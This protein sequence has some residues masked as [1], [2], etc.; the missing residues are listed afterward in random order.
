[1]RTRSLTVLLLVLLFALPAKAQ[2]SF[3]DFV[4]GTQ[5]AA[6]WN[7]IIAEI[8]AVFD[9]ILATLG[10]LEQFE[11]CE[12]LVVPTGLTTD[13]GV[14]FIWGARTATTLDKIRCETDTGTATINLQRDDGASPANIATSNLV[15]DTTGVETTT[16][17]AA[18]DELAAGESLDLVVSAVSDPPP[19]RLTVCWGGTR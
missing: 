3:T 11:E 15:C 8:E 13:D 7:G 9:A 10:V 6:T 2:T 19:L 14:A 5:N 18:E 4:D 12:P 17:E 16:L 1:M